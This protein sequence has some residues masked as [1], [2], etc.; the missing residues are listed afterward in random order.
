MRLGGDIDPA[1]QAGRFSTGSSGVAGRAP[2]ALSAVATAGAGPAIYTPTGCGSRGREDRH[3]Y[4][5]GVTSTLSSMRT[6]PR[7]VR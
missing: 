2:V 4:P 1:M 7:P 5:P 3:S 6:P